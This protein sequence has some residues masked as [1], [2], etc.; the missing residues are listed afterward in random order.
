MIKGLEASRGFPGF[1]SKQL[2][3]LPGADPKARMNATID[4][5]DVAKAVDEL[6]WKNPD[7]IFLSVGGWRVPAFLKELERAG[8]S[9]PVFVS[10]RLDDIFRSP[11]VSYGGDAYQVARDELPNLYNN[12]LRARLFRERPEEWA[13]F[14]RRNPDAFERLDNGCEERPAKPEL[15]VLSRSNIRAIG[16][17]LEFRD[18][19]AMAANIAS[20]QTPAI[21]PDDVGAIRKAIVKGISTHYAAGKGFSREGS[22]TGR[23]GP[24]RGR[25][26]GRLSS[27]RGPAA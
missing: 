26:S 4:P 22:K 16:M 19:I 8:I 6:K 1:A 3:A 7:V 9:V 15:N 11:S 20:D 21:N 17:G 10:G 13:F 24:R 5:A 12:R 14:G 2:L 25:R 18:M 23:S 27:S